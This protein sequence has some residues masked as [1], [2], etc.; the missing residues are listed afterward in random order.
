[1]VAQSWIAFWLLICMFFL[2]FMIVKMKIHPFLSLLFVSI[3]FGL[4]SG[5]GIEQTLDTILN[6]FGSIL[7]SVGIVIVSGIIIGEILTATGGAKKIAQFILGIIGKKKSTLGTNVSGAVVSIPVFSDSGFVLLNPIIKSLS[8]VGNIPYVSLATALMAGLMTTHVLIPPTPGPIAGAE[9]LGADL[10]KFTIYALI[11]AIPIVIVTTLW[12]NSKFLTRKYPKIMVEEDLEQSDE[13]EKTI[14]H[15]PSTFRSFLPIIV[16]I[17]LI[18]GQSF[19][20]QFLSG[21][22]LLISIIIFIGSP[23]IALL[24]GVLLAFL[25]PKKLDGEVTD[26]WVSNAIEKSANILLITA[27]GGSFGSVLK[28]TNIGEFLGGEVLALGFPG[29]LIPF[30]IAALTVTAVGSS[31]VAITTASAIV[32]PLLGDLGISPELAL[33]AV[34]VGSLTVIHTNASLFWMV[35]KMGGMDLKQSYWAV[36][37]TTLIMGITGII[38][39]GILSFFI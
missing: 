21:D 9:L 1:M 31:T 6:G 24:I 28:E 36:T 34:A 15:T 19:S 10:G 35:G 3:F 30:I 4:A 39:V 33:L 26:T 32:M 16:P 2:I 23:P 17:I 14:V 18:I 29:F 11:V 12:A 13:S 22:S 7:G 8:K 37:F 27:A 25:L 38:A 5:L 20:S